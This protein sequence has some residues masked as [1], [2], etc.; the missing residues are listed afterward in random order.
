M[1]KHRRLIVAALLAVAT[2]WLSP[3][4]EAHA[5]LLD[6]I[7]KPGTAVPGP[8]VEVRLH[9]NARIDHA[10]SSLTLFAPDGRE[11]SVTAAT[12]DVP[13]DAM[14][15]KLR[16]LSPGKYRLRWQVLAVD[17]HITRGDVEFEVRA[18]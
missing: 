11:V 16:G 17:G 14:T 9:Y 7:P 12:T 3:S 5:V 1:G 2:A 6:A 10:R 8:D 18:Q 4:A 13:V 15:A